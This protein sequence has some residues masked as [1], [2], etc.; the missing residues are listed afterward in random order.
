MC[1]KIVQKIDQRPGT[2]TQKVR[3]N[4]GESER[5]NLWTEGQQNNRQ[6][7]ISITALGQP[8]NGQKDIEIMNRKMAEKQAEGQ[9]N[10]GLKGNRLTDRKK[11]KEG[12]RKNAQKETRITV[13]SR[14]TDKRTAE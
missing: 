7:D 3:R 5:K 8:R 1:K 11:Q 2:R 13:D 6:K 9:R 12:H 14:I 4:M 10:N